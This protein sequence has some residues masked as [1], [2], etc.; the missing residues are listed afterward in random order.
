MT[1]QSNVK[2]TITLSDPDLDEEELDEATRNLLQEMNKL[3]EVEQ[4]SLVKVE[5]APVGSKSVAGFVLGMLQAEVS[6]TN[7][8]MLLGFLGDRL[9]NKPIEMEV[10]APNGRKLKVKASS[11]EELLVAIKAAEDFVT[12]D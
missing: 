9:G 6:L 5:Q 4:A 2:F 3:D 11:R 12:P 8:K 1:A 10:E 7:I